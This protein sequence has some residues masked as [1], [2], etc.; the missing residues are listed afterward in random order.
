MLGNAWQWCEDPHDPEFYKKS[1]QADP[2]C[3][4]GTGR[5]IRG[6]SWKHDPLFGRSAF[7]NSTSMNPASQADA[8]KGFRVVLSV[9]GVSRNS[10][11]PP[12]ANAAAW[13]I[14]KPNELKSEGG[15]TLKLQEDG[16]ILASGENPAKDTYVL[17]IRN[18]PAKIR[19]LRLD[20]LTHASLP[21][22]GPGRHD[23]FP[24]VLSGI[25]AELVPAGN[26]AP[27][28]AL[29]FAKA[30]ADSSGDDA[31]PE[32]ALDAEDITG[33]SAESGKPHFALFELDEPLAIADGALLRVTLE[34]KHDDAQRALRCFRLSASGEA[35][36]GK[37]TP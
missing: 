19:T 14:L 10:P 1:P 34:F 3:E 2:F 36:A 24:F 6:G 11:P 23:R 32:F 8:D 26:A 21:G 12:A 28:R 9:D 16:S 20:A 25:K 29:K 17:S 13:T 33:W 18:P 7:R 5:L 27:P 30:S 22:Q 31:I 4:T 15:A 35:E 37:P